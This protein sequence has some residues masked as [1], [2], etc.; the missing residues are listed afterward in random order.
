VSSILSNNEKC[1]T[2][3][4]EA[5][6]CM[7]PFILRWFMSH[8]D[9]R[10]LGVHG[11]YIS[12]Q[13]S[14]EQSSSNLT[15][16]LAATIAL[17]QAGRTPWLE[18]YFSL[19]NFLPCNACVNLISIVWTQENNRSTF[20]LHATATSVSLLWAFWTCLDQQPPFFNE[21]SWT[22][23]IIPKYR[24]AYISR[25]TDLWWWWWWRRRWWWW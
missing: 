14:S 19:R 22:T 25:H 10:Q 4:T 21:V 18:C 12:L 13:P 1:L 8:T 9:A 6:N 3:Y 11:W 2:T 17:T 7:D 16:L 5:N 24:V 23:I 20:F 15:Y